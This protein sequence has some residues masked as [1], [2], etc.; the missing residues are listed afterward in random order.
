[1]FCSASPSR[2]YERP[3]VYCALGTVCRN[4][5]PFASPTAL[6]PNDRHLL[7]LPSARPTGLSRNQNSPRPKV[8]SF[9]YFYSTK[10]FTYSSVAQ[11]LCLI[12]HGL[13]NTTECEGT[14]TFTKLLGAISTSSPMVIFPT[15]AALMPI[16]TL[17]PIVGQ[18]FRGP[19][20]ACPITTPLCMLQLR[21]I[22]ALLLMV[23]LY[24]WPIYTPPHLVICCYFQPSSICPYTEQ[25]FIQKPHWQKRN[26]RCFTI[27]RMK[28][29]KI[30]F[31]FATIA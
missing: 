4:T 14:S 6:P 23:I 22:L 24:A 31:R 26:H 10:L 28:D 7:S 17:S 9:L 16:Q 1:M 13:P 5:R 30:N 3:I 18:P 25:D 11:S 2:T 20:F 29:S 27:K 15:M 21:P 19:L 12:M 8:F